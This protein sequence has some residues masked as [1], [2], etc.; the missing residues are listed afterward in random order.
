MQKK[1]IA[2]AVAGLI[3]VPALAQTNVTISGRFAVGYQNYKLSG[4]GVSGQDAYNGI[5]DQSSRIIFN[6]NEDLGGGLLLGASWT[7]ALRMTLV[8]VVP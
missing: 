7:R 2:A 5:S 8:R 6:V 1:L 4:G 3:A